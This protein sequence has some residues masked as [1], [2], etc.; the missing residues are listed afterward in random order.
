MPQAQTTALAAPQ[1]DPNPG[2]RQQLDKFAEDCLACGLCQREC[3]FLARHGQPREIA[4]AWDPQD[5]RALSLAFGCNLCGL[6]GAVC[7]QGLAPSSLFLA[8]RR[9]ASARGAA[10]F[11]QHRGLLAFERRGN[12]P[13]YTWYAL[14]QGCRTVFFPGCNLPG[15]RPRQTWRLY[16]QLRQEEPSLGFVLDCCDKPSHDLGRQ[17]HFLAMFQEMRDWL[18]ERG[19][20]QVLVACPNCHQV[21][22]THGQGLTVRTV[23]QALAEREIAPPAHAAPVLVTMHDPCAV[24]QAAP[25]H[26]AARQLAARAGL[27]VQEMPHHGASTLCCGEGGG[28]GFWCPELSQAWVEQ[29]RREADGLPVVTYCAGCAGILGRSM[30]TSH[31]LDLLLDPR[32]ALA[33]QAPV[34]KAPWTYWNRLRLKKRLQ[35]QVPTAYCRQRPL[36]L[37]SPSTGGTFKLM[38]ELLASLLPGLRRRFSRRGADAK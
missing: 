26:R 8:M 34:S 19:V 17:E 30:P 32:A 7:P 38:L 11:P 18:L 1:A 31:L 3:G 14:P 24:R 16:E 33:G 4:Q 28:V 21:F 35:A 36:S 5:H 15:S 25:V 37:L 6:C 23:Y 9:E 27:T 12:S 20:R 10:D 22:E 29:R 13:R 2:L